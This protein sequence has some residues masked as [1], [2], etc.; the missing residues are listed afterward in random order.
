MYLKSSKGIHLRQ[1]YQKYRLT[2]RAFQAVFY[3]VAFFGLDGF[4]V[5]AL[6]RVKPIIGR[7]MTISEGTSEIQRLVIA[8]HVLAM[9]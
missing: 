9:E 1:P 8:R 7:L 5:P 3:A 2:Q 4:A 6:A